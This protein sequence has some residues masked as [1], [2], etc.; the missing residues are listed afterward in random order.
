MPCQVNKIFPRRETAF[1]EMTIGATLRPS[2]A[3]SRVTGK[4]FLGL[5]AEGIADL[6]VVLLEIGRRAI[7]FSYIETPRLQAQWKL[8]QRH[9]WPRIHLGIVN[10]YCKLHMVVIDAVKPFLDL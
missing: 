10:R 9:P 2:L 8:V 6:L 7:E 5:G 4:L 1:E 3:S